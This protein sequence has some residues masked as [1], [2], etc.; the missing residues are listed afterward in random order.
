MPSSPKHPDEPTAA[1]RVCSILAAAHS[2]TVVSDGRHAEVRFLDGVGTTGRFHLHATWEDCDSRPP[3]R[4]PV[5]LELTDIAPTPVRD[6]LRARVT[7]TGLLAAPYDPESTESACMEFG[8]GVLEDATGRSYVTLH[9]LRTT[10]PDPLAANEA[11][12]LG[13]LVDAHAELVPPLLRLIRPLP[14]RGLLRALPV[15]IDRYGLTLRL[16]Y[17]R[18]QRDVRLPFQKPVHHIDH[19]GPRIRALIAAGRRLTHTGRLLP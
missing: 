17:P 9:E 7:L 15:A 11:C 6:R 5:R 14:D 3:G 18:T 2:M 4:V 12:L 16:E 10:E 8:Q 13:H 1:E 19:V